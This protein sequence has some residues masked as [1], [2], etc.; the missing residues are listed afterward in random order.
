ML[1]V[2]FPLLLIYFCIFNYCILF[3][4]FNRL[5]SYG[6]HSSTNPFSPNFQTVSSF[7]PPPGLQPTPQLPFLVSCQSNAHPSREKDYTP[8]YPQVAM[9]TVP[10]PSAS[11]LS[12]LTSDF[13]F[14]FPLPVFQ[15][16]FSQLRKIDV[17]LSLRN[18]F[19]LLKISSS[20]FPLSGKHIFSFPHKCGTVPRCS[21]F[22][23]HQ[24][25][26]LSPVS[27]P[28][29]YYLFL[30]KF[31]SYSKHTLALIILSFFDVFSSPSMLY[32]FLVCFPSPSLILHLF[33]QPQ[34][35]SF[36][37]PFSPPNELAPTHKFDV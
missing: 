14:F 11:Y 2:A 18:P 19:P 26:S 6:G 23:P 24:L 1:A 28:L 17:S 10:R 25:F 4:L 22:S 15:I 16:I 12:P 27:L 7:F 33:S 21:R 32:S 35:T 34:R 9:V 36:S 29:R 37:S 3:S 31:H 20:S 5:S 8:A 13:D 30:P